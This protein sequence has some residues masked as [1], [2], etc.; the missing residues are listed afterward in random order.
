MTLRL[1]DRPEVTCAGTIAW[2]DPVA[3]QNPNT[4]RRVCA[5]RVD[6]ARGGLRAPEARPGC[7][8]EIVLPGEAWEALAVPLACVEGNG[9]SAAVWIVAEGK[10]QRRTLHLGRTTAV[11]AEVLEGLREGETVLLAR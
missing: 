2:I 7:P 4:D 10:A 9:D 8:V 3:S 1:A 6:L 11:W 5:V